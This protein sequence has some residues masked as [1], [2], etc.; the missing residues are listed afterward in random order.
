MLSQVAQNWQSK[1]KSTRPQILGRWWIKPL[2]KALIKSSSNSLQ[3]LRKPIKNCSV[4][5]NCPEDLHNSISKINSA[6]ENGTNTR[7]EWLLKSN[8][9]CCTFVNLVCCKKRLGSTGNCCRWLVPRMKGRRTGAFQLWGI[10]M[11]SRGKSINLCF[12]DVL[13]YNLWCYGL[14]PFLHNGR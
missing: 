8:E 9:R 5:Q 3:A 11:C 7:I 1:R 6:Y 14:L 10:A 4:I 2:A 12:L 13:M